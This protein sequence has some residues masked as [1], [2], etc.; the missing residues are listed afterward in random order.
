MIAKI[1]TVLGHGTLGALAGGVMVAFGALSAGAT[2]Y[3]ATAAEVDDATC[4][5]SSEANAG[6][7]TNAMARATADGDVV[8]LLPGTYDMTK[9]TP[10]SGVYF[11]VKK[12]ITIRSQDEDASTVTLKGGRLE[13]PARCFEFADNRAVVRGLTFIDFYSTSDTT[14]L[15]KNGTLYGCTFSNNHKSV[16]RGACTYGS[17]CYQC[18]FI[19]NSSTNETRGYLHRGGGACYNGKFY[20]CYFERNVAYNGGTRQMHGGAVCSPSIVSNCVFVSNYASYMGGGVGFDG[21]EN[22]SATQMQVLIIDS[23]FTNNAAGKGG[24]GV[25]GGTVTNCL[26]TGVIPQNTCRGAGTYAANVWNSH[27][28]D[29][30][31]TNIQHYVGAAGAYGCYYNCD[32]VSN[33]TYCATGH[34]CYGGALQSPTYVSNCVFIANGAKDRGGAIATDASAGGWQANRLVVDSYFTNNWVSADGGAIYG[35]TISNC[36]IYGSSIKNGGAGGGACYAKSYDCQFAKNSIYNNVHDRRGGGGQAYGCAVNCVFRDNE[37][38]SPNHRSVAGA[39][40]N[41]AMTNCLVAGSRCVVDNLD[42]GCSAVWAV[43]APCVNCTIVSN[44]CNFKDTGAGVGH[45]INCIFADNLPSDVYKYRFGTTTFDTTLDNCVFSAVAKGSTVTTN[46]CIQVPSIR[47]LKFASDDP[48]AANAYRLTRRSPARDFG[49]DVGMTA[50]DR[51][52]DGLPR[53]Y[54]KAIDAGCYECNIPAPGLL[55]FCR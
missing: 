49:L 33:T 50:E 22:P 13:V 19:G 45:F 41:V 27:F 32:F 35:V 44:S 7:L 30:H 17:D 46:D 11:N 3:F 52:L 47:A 37:D 23:Y 20:Q 8:T 29:N 55:L 40:C 6:S 12:A 39:C 54:G 36:V 31:M 43:D 38:I 1:R 26:F 18:S 25:Y 4:D 10:A 42:M 9:F 2:E 24:G 15:I 21:A 16:T 51:D 5:C 14:A 53:V 28:I 48:D 34:S